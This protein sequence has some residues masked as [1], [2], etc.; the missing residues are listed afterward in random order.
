MTLPNE[1]LRAIKNTRKF[2]LD[3]LSAKKTP[4]IPREIR[5]RAYQLLNHYPYDYESLYIGKNF[6]KVLLFK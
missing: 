5:Q 1:Q 6:S 2:L 4:R 3:L